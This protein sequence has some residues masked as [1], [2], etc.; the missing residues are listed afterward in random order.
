MNT[1]L[2][3]ISTPNKLEEM[4]RITRSFAKPNATEEIAS[5]ILSTIESNG[6]RIK[7][8]EHLTSVV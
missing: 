8:K 7:D 1:I 2:D 4:S 3:L 6:Q 5:L